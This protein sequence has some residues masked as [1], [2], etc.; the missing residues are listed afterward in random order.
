VARGMG[1]IL[2]MIGAA[3]LLAWIMVAEQIPD[4]A[5]RIMLGITTDPHL[6]LLIINIFLLLLGMVIDNFAA[7]VLLVPILMPIVHQYGIDPVHF[8]VIMNV[9]LMIGAIT[10]PVGLCLFVTSRVAGVPFESAVREVLPFIGAALVALLVITYVPA[11]S[12]ALPG[13]LK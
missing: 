6:L 9:N 10:P 3:S 8:G 1:E 5:A 11:L 4:A 7:M 2:L 12:L 13:L